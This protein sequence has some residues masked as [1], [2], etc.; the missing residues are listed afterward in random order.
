M[1][2]KREDWNPWLIRLAVYSLPAI[3]DV[4]LSAVLQAILLR[5]AELTRSGMI[6]GSL[7]AVWAVVYMVFSL[8]SGRFVTHRRMA[9]LLVGACA[10]MA[11]I[12]LAFMRWPNLAAMYLLTGVLGVAS[13]AFF[14]PFQVFMK[15]VDEGQQKDVGRS[16]GSYT[17]AWSC[18]YAIGP[19]VIGWL[20]GSGG[21]AGW[22][23]CMKFCA[24]MSAISAIGV[25]LL[26][27]QAQA[28][29][30]DVDAFPAIARAANPTVA[31]S[32]KSPTSIG[33]AGAATEYTPL[34]ASLPDLAWMAWIFSGIAGMMVSMVRSQLPIS[35]ERLAVSAQALGN[36]LAVL[37][38]TQGLTA[39]LLGR[40]HGWMYRPLPMLG[41]GLCGVLGLALFAAG[42][43]M[44]AWLAAGA[45]MGLFTGGAYFYLVYHSLIHP[46]RGPRYVA[47]NE[48][49]MGVAGAAGP[50]IGGWLGDS[51]GLRVPYAVA[52]GV[53]L[54]AVS[55]Q[56]KLHAT[57][58]ASG[59]EAVRSQR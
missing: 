13:V 10:V 47:V 41:L 31:A 15:L 22:N 48:A 44:S 27:R 30:A 7:S 2:W 12:S 37:S 42:S 45:V 20:W 17:F 6:T 4:V 26:R 16:A 25:L 28:R 58:G 21:Q 23:A 32:V 3:I 19:F 55:V 56:A 1:T 51:L 18:G 34:G 9:G 40:I 38:L 14:V 49:V 50:G 59:K 35:A 8:A 53:V 54:I 5:A 39:L 29:P 46:T 33:T 57:F 24:V 43:G 11:L 36:V 52:S